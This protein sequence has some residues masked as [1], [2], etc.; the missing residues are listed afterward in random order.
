MKK[1]TWDEIQ[2]TILLCF[3]FGMWFIFEYWCY[4]N[5]AF[6][7]L[8]HTPAVRLVL[9]KYRNWTFRVYLYQKSTWRR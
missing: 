5:A 3:A 4:K 2:Q 7:A 8:S 9:N 1:E 6:A